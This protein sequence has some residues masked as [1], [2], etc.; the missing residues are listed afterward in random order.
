[1]R[2]NTGLILAVANKRGITVL[3]AG[4]SVVNIDPPLPSDP[5][6]FVRRAFAVRDSLDECQV[7]ALVLTIGGMEMVILTADLANIDSYFADRIRSTIVSTT[8]IDYDSILLN[9]SHSHAGLWPRKNHEKLH[10]EFSELTPAEAVYFEKLPFDFASAVVKALAHQRPARV[11]GGT[12]VAKGIAVNRR[13]RTEDGRTILGWNKENFIDEEVPTIRIDDYDG[14]AIATVVGF[15]CHPVSLSGEVPLSGSDFIGPLRNQVELIRGGICLFLQGAAGNILPLEAFCDQPGPEVA[16]G[17]RLGIEAIHAVV[18][19]EPR[20][21]EIQRIEYGSVTPIALY[22]KRPVNPQP[23]Q[24][25]GSRRKVLQL[26]LNPPMT[27]SEMEEELVIKRTDYVSKS[28]SGAGRDILNPIGY[29]INWLAKMITWS[30]ESSLPTHVEG[31]IW[32]GRIGDV[33]ILGSPGEIF[34]EI[35]FQVRQASPFRTTIFAGY[36][37]GVLGYVSTRAEYPFGGYEPSVAQRGYGHP[38][39][40]A[41]EAGELIAAESIALLNEL[42]QAK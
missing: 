27:I 17:N 30:R 35:G 9:V 42:Y 38:A 16:M 11:S 39:P 25:M 13:E 8:G 14:K 6:G 18:D 7:R 40:F 5:Q 32:A 10:G 1:M 33:A 19:V 2:G 3:L 41:P 23:V 37:Q 29:H 31:E 34:S 36:C 24:P 21:M 20:E 4:S 26:P 28:G 12:G 15:G 22:R